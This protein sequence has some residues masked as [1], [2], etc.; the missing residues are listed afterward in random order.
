MLALLSIKKALILRKNISSVRF[1]K[2][3]LE[4]DRIGLRGR[5][6][7]NRHKPTARL[8]KPLGFFDS[9]ELGDVGECPAARTGPVNAPVWD[10]SRP[11]G[12]KAVTRLPYLEEPKG[13]DPE[14]PKR[15]I[16][17]RRRIRVEARSPGAHAPCP[18]VAYFGAETEIVARPPV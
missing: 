12:S 13:I 9:T 1:K 11:E 4:F 6:H 5:C 8:G 7:G 3:I 16:L 2:K 18:V 17:I 10:K 14:G 15:R